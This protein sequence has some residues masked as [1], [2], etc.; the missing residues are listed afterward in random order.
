MNLCFD[1][2]RWRGRRIT[3]E[4]AHEV[5]EKRAILWSLDREKLAGSI[6]ALPERYRLVLHH[7]FVVGLKPREIDRRDAAFGESVGLIALIAVGSLLLPLRGNS[8][9]LQSL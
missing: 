1:I 9:F 5:I 2:R 4:S 3:V 6:D 8:R 7:R